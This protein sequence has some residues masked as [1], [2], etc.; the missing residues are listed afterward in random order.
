VQ[1]HPPCLRLLAF[2]TRMPFLHPQ[3]RRSLCFGTTGSS[4]E[5]HG[6]ADMKAATRTRHIRVR[7]RRVRRACIRTP[8]SCLAGIAQH[9]RR[10]ILSPAQ[11]FLCFTFL[12]EDAAMGRAPDVCL[13]GA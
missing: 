6:D 11:S 10:A 9:W 8:A 2:A 4:C 12:S 5:G 13:C 7:R 1:I 3:H